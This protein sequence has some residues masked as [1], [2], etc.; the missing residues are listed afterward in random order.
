MWTVPVAHQRAEIRFNF[1][2]KPG[3]SRFSIE[4]K[5]YHNC[6]MMISK[7]IK[8]KNSD[9]RL[10]WLLMLFKGIYFPNEFPQLHSMV[11][12]EVQHKLSTK[13]VL[14]LIPQRFFLL[15]F[16]FVFSEFFFFNSYQWL[17]GNDPQLY[18]A[19]SWRDSILDCKIILL[20]GTRMIVNV[21]YRY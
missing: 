1:Y 12:E 13:V 17:C 3:C 9:W 15:L 2:P 18:N 5:G 7:E 4:P 10:M 19:F 8:R 6:P 11:I 14:Q 21:D 20:H 16:C